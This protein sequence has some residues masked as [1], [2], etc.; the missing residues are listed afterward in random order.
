MSRDLTATEA[1]AR[2]GVKRDTLYAYVSRGMVSRRVS[3]DGR[4]SRFDAAE[5]DS[6][7]RGRRR[8]ATGEIDAVLATSITS[9]DDAVL[10]IRGHDLPDLVAG[11]ASFEAVV[12]LLWDAAPG[13]LTAPVA[14]R[15]EVQRVQALLSADTDLLQ[16]LRITVAMAGADPLRH[17]LSAAGVVGAGRAL[18]G[19]MVDGLPVRAP[20]A[21]PDRSAFG[22]PTPEDGVAAEPPLAAR[23]WARL[24]AAPTSPARVRVL[25]AAMALLVDHGLAVSTFGAR[26][27]ASVRAD[28]Y[29]VVT[30]GLGVIGG[31]RHGAASAQVHELLERAA[32][33]GPAAAVGE[34]HRRGGFIPGFGHVI[35]RQRDPRQVLLDLHL[36]RGWPDDPRMDLLDGVFTA[37]RSRS[38]V[39]ANVDLTLGAL[40]WLTGWSADSGEAIFAIART[41]GW[42]AHALEEYDEEPLRFRPRARYVGPRT[43]SPESDGGTGDQA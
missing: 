4:S 6:L 19:L 35:Y 43:G 10:L 11:G 31:T 36:R 24:G 40:T 7:R 28:P 13:A 20:A 14:R 33:V 41:A 38:E 2:L 22:A 8:R 23:L 18:I 26:L 29:S 32:V 27:A 9:I 21:A 34:F 16:R 42:L 5:I 15:E 1:A 39:V 37:V 3:T 12:D 17:D 30:A 25:D